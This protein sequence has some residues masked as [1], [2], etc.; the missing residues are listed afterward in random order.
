MTANSGGGVAQ[1]RGSGASVFEGNGAG[2]L[3]L[4]RRGGGEDLEEG[5][6]EAVEKSGEDTAAAAVACWSWSPTEGRGRPRGGPLGRGLL[7]RARGCT[8]PRLRF[9][10]GRPSW[11]G[12]EKVFY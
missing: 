3:R 9:A 8:G 6:G 5:R 4:Y 12:P 2:V 11:P 1:L 10:L 7:Q